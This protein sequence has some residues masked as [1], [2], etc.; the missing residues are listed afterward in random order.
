[1]IVPTGIATDDSLKKFFTDLVQKG[2]LRSYFGFKNERFLF[3]RPVEHTVTFG[4]L[5]M[6]GA[7]MRSDAME[8]CWL[9]YT[10]P[11]IHEPQRRVELYAEDF[12][13]FN[14]NTR[15]CPVFRTEHDAQL[16]RKI[17]EL[18]PVLVNERTGQNPWGVQ[19]RQGLFNMTSDS[20]LFSKKPGP[21]L[22]PLYEAKMMHQ[23]DHRWA[24]YDPSLQ[25]FRDCTDEEKADLNFKVT[26]RYWVPKEEVKARLGEWHCKWL[27]AFRDIARSTD[28]RTA[29]FTIL[30][31]VPEDIVDLITDDILIAAPAGFGKT[32]FCKWQTLNDLRRLRDEQSDVVPIYVPLH[33]H[34][35]GALGTFESMFLRS[36]EFVLL[37]QR[38]RSSGIAARRRF[39][40]YLDGLDEVTTVE[41]QAELLAVARQAR[42]ADPSIQLVVTSREH[43]IG[44]HLHGLR[45]VRLREFDDEQ[46]RQL[47]TKWFEG[48]STKMNVFFN[49]LA[50]VPNVRS[51]MR[52]PLLATLILGVYRNT[53]TLPESRIR[54]YDMFVNLLAG[55]W[56]VAK[57]IHRETQF[58]PTPKIAVLI[59]LAGVLHLNARRD[60]SQFEFKTAVSE[61]LPALAK[62]WE[63][64]L[65]EILQD[66]LLVPVGPGFGFA[67]LSFQEFLAA[68]EL[69]DPRGRRAIQAFQRFLLGEDWWHEVL[70]FYVEM[71]GKPQDMTSFIGEMTHRA[72]LKSGDVNVK[73]RARTLLE[74]LAIAFPG[75]KPQLVI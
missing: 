26:S 75:A 22:L 11:E 45:R 14:P 2:S 50:T 16:T 34:S 24:T 4:L 42:C 32:S 46:V 37:W 31:P 52:V 72:M 9:C 40:L 65:D 20:H 18:A 56:D 57:N 53:Q 28:E 29:I 58:G 10:V 41:R 54:L 3:A 17:Y 64:L 12:E 25:G 23:F 8:F 51:L 6:L 36:P 1:M 70:S 19:F 5:T 49:K 47:A 7:R 59:K 69:L 13:R 21:G 60:C 68:K 48:D 30:P 33:T 73:A 44:K 38:Q 74:R 27:M 62:A 55:G 43:V 15:T 63:K 67:H 35:Q 39:R 71:T 61:T 66:G